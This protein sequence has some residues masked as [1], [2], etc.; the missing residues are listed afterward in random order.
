VSQADHAGAVICCICLQ[1][2][3]LTSNDVKHSPAALRACG[4]VFGWHCVQQW[5]SGSNRRCPQCNAACVGADVLRLYAQVALNASAAANNDAAM[6]RQA[7][8]QRLEQQ[9]QTSMKESAALRRQNRLLTASLAQLA[10]LQ[11]ERDAALRNQEQLTLES[12]AMRVELQ[13]LRVRLQHAAAVPL[14]KRP[15]SATDDAEAA[16][17]TAER[18]AAAAAVVPSTAAAQSAPK[19]L[20]VARAVR[21]RVGCDLG[22]LVVVACGNDRGRFDFVKLDGLQLQY[23]STLSSVHQ[24]RVRDMRL[25]APL[26]SGP[27]AEPMILSAAGR[28]LQLTSLRSNNVALSVNLAG[29]GWS[30]VAL[31]GL[32]VPTALA[33][34]S[35]SGSVVVYDVRRPAAPLL[36]LPPAGAGRGQPLFGL[37]C[38]SDANGGKWLVGTSAGRL[39]SWQL[40]TEHMSLVRSFAPVAW[41]EREK[42]RSGAVSS[43]SSSSSS[44]SL[45]TTHQLSLSIVGA[46]F[47]HRL[48]QGF[49]PD[50]WPPPCEALFESACGVAALSEA[51][52]ALV[53]CSDAVDSKSNGDSFSLLRLERGRAV[54]RTDLPA[55]PLVVSG[56]NVID[57]HIDDRWIAGIS[58]AG[59]CVWV[60]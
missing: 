15:R 48:L 59:L 24:H 54:A 49:V 25:Y 39:S 6:Q 50:V 4:H 44:S 46:R 43:S 1:A 3:D 41:S 36:T 18:S 23:G 16:A 26:P 11:A 32:G 38:V 27:F 40:D 10:S 57:M 21:V 20:C 9:L 7:M 13:Q 30:C 58:T 22:G 37:D 42:C 56:S 53:V 8:E 35:E 28:V 34:G 52:D 19:T 45:L 5:A 55:A 51:G 14:A 33:C 60:S 2:V 12:A 29:H 31:P 17:D 47:Q